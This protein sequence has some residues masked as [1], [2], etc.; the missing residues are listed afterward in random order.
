MPAL[1]A[2]STAKCFRFLQDFGEHGRELISPEIALRLLQALCAGG[3][4]LAAL[5]SKSGVGS[6]EL[7]GVLERSVLQVPTA[8]QACL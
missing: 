5:A 4:D 3:S 1:P 7:Q 6:Q 8:L 2:P